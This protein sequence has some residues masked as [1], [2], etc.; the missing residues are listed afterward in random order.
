MVKIKSLIFDLDETLV[1]LP[2]DW[3]SA[4]EEVRKRTGRNFTNFLNLLAEV[5]NTDEYRKVSKI[6]ESFEL[7]ALDNVQVLDNSKEIILKL[8]GKYS[9]SLVTLQGRR[10]AEEVLRKLGIRKAFKLVITRDD[11]ATRLMQLQI[12]LEKTGFKPEETVVI[13]DKLNDVESALKLKC[14]AV[15]IDRRNRAELLKKPVEKLFIIKDLNELEEV[16]HSLKQEKGLS[17]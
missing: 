8:S 9:L 1:K 2:V 7:Y 3:Q 15:L 6:I 12:I 14:W 13:G 11:A 10:I 4:Y 16:L 17:G 5:W